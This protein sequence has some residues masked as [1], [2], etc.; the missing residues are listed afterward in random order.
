M[1]YVK[2]F[3]LF[4]ILLLLSITY[5]GCIKTLY[6]DSSIIH[7]DNK[8]LSDLHKWVALQK[9]NATTISIQNN[10]DTILNNADWG[11][12]IQMNSS[13]D[14]IIIYVPLANS[15][16]GLEFFLDHK[17]MKIDSGN[18]VK[19]NS[20]DNNSI[21]SKFLGVMAYY[22]SIILNN[23]QASNFNGTITSFSIINKFLYDYT[24]IDGKMVSHGIISP[25]IEISK[26]NTKTNNIKLGMAC[27]EW[28]HY[29]FW[30]NGDVIMDY[31]YLVCDS[32]PCKDVAVNITNGET[33]IRSN[34]SGSGIEF[35]APQLDKSPCQLAA[36]HKN[37]YDS[38]QNSSIYTSKFDIISNPNI[39][40]EQTTTFGRSIN[41][42]IIATDIRIGTALNVKPS[43]NIT[44]PF[45]VLHSH[46]NISPPSIGDFYN[47]VINGNIFPSL[48]SSISIDAAGNMYS[49]L[50]TD[51]NKLNTFWT[52]NKPIYPSGPNNPPDFPS[53]ISSDFYETQNSIINYGFNNT[54]GY[55]MA[56]SFILDKY[57]TGIQLLKLNNGKFE[58]II[59]NS[60]DNIKF[61]IIKCP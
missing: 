36:E 5:I 60:S 13:N 2:F 61:I 12:S 44:N 1:N 58:P 29:T 45:V 48:E 38:L 20:Q 52:N 57:N 43:Y 27:Q 16:V 35:L 18:I 14:N 25:K 47:L 26:S 56:L 24:F 6:S 28:A 53:F 19:V 50:I 22:E 21:G 55:S 46:T 37:M 40:V 49:L 31:T 4:L 11:K 15:P 30:T 32:D 33:N 41:G 9:E 3:K 54:E 34:C 10:I 51:R 39:I 42:E 8:T 59:V 7:T 17:T 23:K